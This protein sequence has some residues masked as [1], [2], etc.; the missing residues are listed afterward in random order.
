MSETPRQAEPKFFCDV[1]GHHTASRVLETRGC[2]RRRE[3]L[4]CGDTYPTKEI[5]AKRGRPPRHRA[6][7]RQSVLP[8]QETR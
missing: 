5:R 8:I 4:V 6:P 2:R 3:C 1:C 7:S